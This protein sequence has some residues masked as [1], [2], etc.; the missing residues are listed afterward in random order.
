M[1]TKKNKVIIAVSAVIALI[2]VIIIVIN[3]FSS[4]KE[5][6]KEYII[7]DRTSLSVLIDALGKVNFSNEDTAKIFSKG[8][9]NPYTLNFLRELQWRFGKE[10]QTFESHFEKVCGYLKANVQIEDPDSLCDLYKKYVEYEVSLEEKLGAFGPIT[11]AKEALEALR[12]MQEFRRDFFGSDIADALFVAEVK[13]QE[14]SIRRT[15]IVT[16]PELYGSEKLALLE[17]LNKRMWGDEADQVDSLTIMNNNFNKYQESKQIYSRDMS[18][19]GEA[20]KKQF[21]SML[22]NN[23][24]TP[25]VVA[26]FNEIDR[27]NEEQKKNEEQYYALE[28][29]IINDPTI[30]D[31]EKDEKI[32]K[33]QKE[34]FGKEGWAAF[35]R[36]DAIKKGRAGIVNNASSSQSLLEEEM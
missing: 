8:I 7:S 26:K 30:S 22:R 24:F 13:T 16:D 3:M 18:E 10:D 34:I 35:K 9:I 2:F 19:M 4:N 36:R 20:E 6:P 11:N 17:D 1:G 12:K 15:A 29:Q 33:L 25:D 31:H 28:K 23:Y 27:Q 32:T 5:L 14:Y 21:D